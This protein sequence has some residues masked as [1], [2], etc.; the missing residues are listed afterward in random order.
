MCVK[1]I[2]ARIP[3]MASKAVPTDLAVQ[4]AK[5]H[6]LTLVCAAHSDSFMV[7]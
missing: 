1:A 3:I 4:M 7:M 2:R 5:E 6:G